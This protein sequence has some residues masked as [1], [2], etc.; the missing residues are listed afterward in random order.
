VVYPP[1]EFRSKLTERH[2]FLK[3]VM[4]APKI[5]LIGNDNELEELARRKIAI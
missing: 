3:T 5:F 2:H 1:E 4:S